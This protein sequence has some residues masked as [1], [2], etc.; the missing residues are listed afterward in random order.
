MSSLLQKAAKRDPGLEKEAQQWMQAVVGEPFPAGSYEDAL[1]D[2]V[3]LCKSVYM[4][5]VYIYR[6]QPP[7]VHKQTAQKLCKTDYVIQSDPH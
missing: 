2:G 5:Y 7:H 1:K 6:L 4:L 3:Y